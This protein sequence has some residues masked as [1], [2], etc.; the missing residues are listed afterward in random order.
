[1]PGRHPAHVGLGRHH[2]PD[3]PG[4]SRRPPGESGAVSSL[5]SSGITDRPF[6]PRS[7]GRSALAREWPACCAEGD[8]KG[9]PRDAERRSSSRAP[10][11]QDPREADGPFPPLPAGTPPGVHSVIAPSVQDA[12]PLVRSIGAPA[13][14]G[15]VRPDGVRGRLPGRPVRLQRE[16]TT[17]RRPCDPLASG[18]RG[19]HSQESMVPR[20][21]GACRSALRAV[22]VA[23]RLAE[24]RERGRCRAGCRR[25]GTDRPWPTGRNGRILAHKGVHRPAPAQYGEGTTVLTTR[26]AAT[27][28]HAGRHAAPQPCGGVPRG[29]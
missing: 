20:L 14:R 11:N 24:V 15:V 27:Q 12:P 22:A 6:L 2:R 1:M 4:A 18:R 7:R 25:P 23:A 8:G 5:G 28:F 19:V 13:A 17:T 10:R 29:A 9:R 3:R 26:Q 21:T 16:G